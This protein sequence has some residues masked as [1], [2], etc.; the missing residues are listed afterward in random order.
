MWLIGLFLRL[1]KS[2]L[3]YFKFC[4]KKSRIDLD[5]SIGKK[6][7]IKKDDEDGEINY[8][9]E[10]NKVFNKKI[11]WYF[12]KYMKEYVDYYLLFVYVY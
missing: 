5:C 8:I 3:F 7:W 2:M 4:E 1:I 12:D 11:F 10:R 9:N 6:K